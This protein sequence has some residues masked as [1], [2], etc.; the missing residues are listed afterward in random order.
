MAQGSIRWVCKLCGLER[1]R[2][3][4]AGEVVKEG[5]LPRCRHAGAQYY[6]VFPIGRKVGRPRYRWVPA[7][8]EL[9]AAE[10]LKT[11]TMHA[12]QHGMYR[13]V[14]P[15]SFEEF[16]VQWLTEYAEIELRD[17]SY[18]AAEAITRVHLVPFF[19]RYALDEIDEGLARKYMALKRQTRLVDD[20]RKTR[21][22]TPA[23]EPGE[24]PLSA[25]ELARALGKDVSRV[26]AYRRRGLPAADAQRDGRN[27]WARPRGG[28]GA[29]SGGSTPE[30]W[31]YLSVAKAW[32]DA[33]RGKRMKNSDAPLSKKTIRNHMSL[34]KEMLHH[35]VAWGHLKYN[36]LSKMKLPA[37]DKKEMQFLRPEEVY[38]LL[39]GSLEDGTPCIDSK[40][41]LP[42]K[43]AIFTGLRESEEWGLRLCDLD[44]ERCQ[45]TVRQQLIE[46]SKRLPGEARGRYQRKATPPKTERGKRNVDVPADLMEEIYWYV[47]SSLPDERADRLLFTNAKGKPIAQKVADAALHR[48]LERAK[49]KRIR[50]HDLRHSYAALQIHANAKPKYLQVQMGHSSVTETMELYGHLYDDRDP[51]QANRAYGLV[52]GNVPRPSAKRGSIAFKGELVEV[53]S[54]AAQMRFAAR[55]GANASEREVSGG[56]V[57]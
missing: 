17:K 5:P 14:V 15:K 11:D 40:W 50:W 53:R 32:L 52:F 37:F 44:F 33:H 39:K 35:A 12:V 41:Y 4:K 47:K 46:F 29:G 43:V 23:P 28:K 13:E 56:A 24:S 8:K 34:L 22:E 36:R 6:I 7:G 9:K 3:R 55:T 1:A 19:G 10:R 57:H 21:W 16:A 30:A 45:I 42:I 18:V 54:N 48:A 51:A 31:Y 27:R 49:L 2:R 26:Y 38:A 25:V 20:G